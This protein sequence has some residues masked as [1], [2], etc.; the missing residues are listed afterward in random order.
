MPE[1]THLSQA[2]R[3][4]RSAPDL[5][6]SCLQHPETL[7]SRCNVPLPYRLNFCHIRL[8]N[9]LPLTQKNAVQPMP[10]LRPEN[11]AGMISYPRILLSPTCY[12]EC[13]YGRTEI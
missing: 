12:Q 8:Y 5:C 10:C 1:T 9:P 3:S 2:G 13:L 11:P 6:E 4:G 7:N